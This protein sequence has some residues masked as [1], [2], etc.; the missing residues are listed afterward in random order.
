MTELPFD[1]FRIQCLE[2]AGLRKIPQHL[3]EFYWNTEVFEVCGF[4]AQKPI[5]TADLV[6]RCF[7]ARMGNMI[8]GQKTRY[9]IDIQEHRDFYTFTVF[10]C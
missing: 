7:T 2:E 3:K 8:Y 4:V 9:A 6:N 10:L 5:S 1:T